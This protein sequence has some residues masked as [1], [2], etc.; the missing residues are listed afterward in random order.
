MKWKNR[1]PRRQ[2][3]GISTFPLPRIR[4]MIWDMALSLIDFVKWDQ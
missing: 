3:P 4:C 1:G 2:K